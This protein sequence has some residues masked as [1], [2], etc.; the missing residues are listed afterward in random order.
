MFNEKLKALVV[1][2][3]YSGLGISLVENLN[4]WIIYNLISWT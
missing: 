2:I 4:Y 1:I 3:E